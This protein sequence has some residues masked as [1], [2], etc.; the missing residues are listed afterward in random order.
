[1]HQPP[2]NLLLHQ[3]LQHPNPLPLQS[4]HQLP[5]LQPLLIQHPNL[6]LHQLL[7]NPL[8]LQSLH[9]PPLILLP[10]PLPLQPLQR[11]NNPLLRK[12]LL[13]LKPKLLLN[14]QPQK[15]YQKL[16]QKPWQLLLPLLP[17]QPSQQRKPL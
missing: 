14:K 17:P 16:C 11:L 13:L 9:Q 12:L 3:L 7:L 2:L 15:L 10:R 8:L 1:L 5:L 4:L 6:L